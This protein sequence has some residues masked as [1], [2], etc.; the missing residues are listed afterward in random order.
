[1][2]Q[3]IAYALDK[4][5]LLKA[6]YWGIGETENNQPFVNRS[7]FY[8]PVKDRENDRAKARQLLAEAGYP[9]G[10]KLEFLQRSVAYDMACAEATIGQLKNVGIEGSMRVI[11]RAP[12]NSMMQKGDYSISANSVSERYDWDDAYYM[13]LHSSEI[14]K[15]NWSRYGNKELDGLMEKGRVTMKWEDRM[16]IY[17]KV[18]EIIKEDLPIMCISKNVVGI[19]LADHVKGY[20]KGF[21]VRFAWTGGGLKYFWMDK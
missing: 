15:N 4:K 5:E 16:A 1:M 20:R 8:I 2:R 10:F 12:F 3:A 11:D 13:N 7:R 19:A 9:K 14:D 21:A 6:M 17:R 18:V